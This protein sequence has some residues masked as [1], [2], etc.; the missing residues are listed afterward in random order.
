MRSIIGTLLGLF[1]FCSG[2]SAK[3]TSKELVLPVPVES[4][5]ESLYSVI[6]LLDVRVDTSAFGVLKVG[7]LSRD[8]PVV[9]SVPLSD[10]LSV[11]VRAMA[12]KE[13]GNGELLL[14]LRNF[15]FN[16]EYRNGVERGSCALRASLFARN[17]DAY[18]FMSTLDTLV[19]TYSMDEVSDSILKKGGLCLSE[20]IGSSL[21]KLPSD[22]I[23]YSFDD[24]Q[25]FDAIEKARLPLYTASRL[26]DGLYQSY[27]SFAQQMPEKPVIVQIKKEKIVSVRSDDAKREKVKPVGVYAV[28]WK[29]KAYVS[30]D[31]EFIPVKK[32]N[33][34][35]HFIANS[36][37]YRYQAEAAAV[38]GAMYGLFWGM[39]YLGGTSEPILCE[40]KIDYITGDFVQIRL[41]KED[42]V[43]N[44]H[45]S[46]FYDSP[47]NN[48]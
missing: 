10:Q 24:L 38:M 21:V 18:R 41:L 12:G 13:A 22:S 34:D 11:M 15:T 5:S 2:V 1:V 14:L 20:F 6:S 26:T 40:M 25:N 33:N 32:M 17:Q 35:F 27:R 19:Q 42:E 43:L 3:E 30:K 46:R 47:A 28:V 9:C 44:F 48:K 29:G 37:E 8:V 45:S 16:E 31:K 4:A 39:V 36:S 23:H 7:T